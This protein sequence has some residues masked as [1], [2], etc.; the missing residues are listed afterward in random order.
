[1]NVLNWFKSRLTERSSLLSITAILALFG[2]NI[3][4]ELQDGI[5]QVA[6]GVGAVIGFAT[7][8]KEVKKK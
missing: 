7:K 4:P 2:I 5:I 3:A 8:D 6:T 1:M